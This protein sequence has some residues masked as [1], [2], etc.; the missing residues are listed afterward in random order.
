MQISSLLSDSIISCEPVSDLER[1]RRFPDSWLSGEKYETAGRESVTEDG[2][3]LVAPQLYLDDRFFGWKYLK[4]LLFFPAR[5]FFTLGDGSLFFESA[6]LSASTAFSL[7]F[8]ARS[9][10]FTTSKHRVGI[11]ILCNL[12][13]HLLYSSFIIASR[14]LDRLLSKK[15]FDILYDPNEEIICHW[16]S[17]FCKRKYI[18]FRSLHGSFLLARNTRMDSPHIM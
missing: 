10:T 5:L 3:E 18:S 16:M 12:T 2:I 13:E 1:Q 4:N 11:E 7:P 8:L 9:S 14:H 15:V 6:P 17:L